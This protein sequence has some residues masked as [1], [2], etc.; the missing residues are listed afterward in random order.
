MNPT[1]V[2][3]VTGLARDALLARIDTDPV[4]GHSARLFGHWGGV[5]RIVP[6]IDEAALDLLLGAG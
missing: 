1:A 3:R 5:D 2:A 4:L 6:D